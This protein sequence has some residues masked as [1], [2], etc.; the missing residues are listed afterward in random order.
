M[1]DKKILT[2]QEIALVAKRELAK[3]ILEKRKILAD[4]VYFFENYVYIENKSG[5]VSE[6]SILFE[7]FDEQK[8]ALKEINENKLNIVIKARQ[9]GMTWM[10]VA[11]SLHKSLK[12]QQYTTVILSQTED[13]MQEAISRFEYIITRLPKTWLI[14]EYNKENL[15]DNTVYLYEKKSDEITIYHPT[16][17]EGMRVTSSVKGLVSTPKAGRSITADLIIFDEWAYHENAEEVFAAAY[18]TINRPDDS[19]CFI[20]ISTNKRGSF[21]E[22]IITDCLDEGSMQFHMIFLS[23]F[24]DTRR[25]ERWYNATKAALPNTYQIEYPLT[26]TDALSAGILTAFPEFDPKVHVCDDF[27]IPEHWIKWGSC[28]NGYR[29][30]FAWYKFAIDEDGTTYIY[31]E[32]TRDKLKDPI[33]NYKDQAEKF[34][35]DCTINITNQAKEEIDELHLGYETDGIEKYKLENLQ[36]VVFGLDA[37]NRDSS[38]GTGKSLMD[39]YKSGGFNYSTARATT[40]RKLKKDAMHEYLRPY[41][42]ETKGKMTAKLQICKSCKFL[43]KYIPML[44]VEEDNPNVVADNSKIDNCYDGAIYGI[45]G[46]PRNNSKSLV[47]NESRLT[48]FKKE[49]MKFLGNRRKKNGIIN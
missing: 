27:T 44:V 19:G 9:L 40:D 12:I 4:E 15:Q 3:R 31:Y 22:N 30:P 7:M 24:A 34:M 46:S 32:Y 26:V 42:D 8:R 16:N 25:D 49:K 36:Y 18:P 21:F 20:G 45:L 2:Q 37:F 43:I 48:K 14:K 10:A 1:E 38:R 28:D 29:D 11:H 6:R 13:Y 41:F 47:K 33:I 5:D 35:R 23:A 39:F 17:E